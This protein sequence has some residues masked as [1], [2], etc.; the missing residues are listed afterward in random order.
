L[1]LFIIANFPDFKA[2]LR[3]YPASKLEY[4]QKTYAL[5][6]SILGKVASKRLV[7][8]EEALKKMSKESKKL[9]REFNLAQ[10]ANLD[11]E[12]KVA[13]LAEALKRCQDEKR[14]AEDEKKVTQGALENSKKDLEK[15]QN[16]H[17]EDLKLIENLCKDHDKSSKAAEDL[18]VNNVDLAK[19][20]SA[21]EQKIQDLE[22]AL[23]EQDEASGQEVTEIVTKMKLLFEEYRNALRDF[24]IRP[25]PFPVNE[26][27]SKFMDWINNEFKALPGAISGASNFAATFSVESI[28]KLLHDFDCADLAKFREKLTN[29]PDASSTSIIRVNEDVS[30]S[31]SSSQENFGSLVGRRLQRRSLMLN[32]IRLVSRRRRWF[33]KAS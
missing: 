28:L 3:T 10:V 15:L 4:Y 12:K 33:C 13:E 27:I 26:E 24:G 14:V 16:T 29:F 8:Q 32:W 31:S 1:I 5:K 11:L 25:A 22:R 19:T 30:A 2:L 7:E 9:K 23:A 6:A 20:L 17:E 21:K 18:R